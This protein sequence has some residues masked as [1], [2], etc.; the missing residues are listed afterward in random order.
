LKIRNPK[1]APRKIIT[2]LNEDEESIIFNG[3]TIKIPGLHQGINMA[4]QFCQ[5]MNTHFGQNFNCH[6]ERKNKRCQEGT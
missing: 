6:K 1:Q 5:N 4:Q 2:I 3:N